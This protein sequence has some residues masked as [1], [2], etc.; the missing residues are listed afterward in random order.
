MKNVTGRGRFRAASCASHRCL[1]PPC[2]RAPKFSARTAA[3]R[4]N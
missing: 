1:S 2:C 3:N 4:S